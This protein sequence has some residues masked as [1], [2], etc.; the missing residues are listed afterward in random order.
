MFSAN[1]PRWL[2]SV[3][4]P[5]ANTKQYSGVSNPLGLSN[6][7]AFGRIWPANAPFGDTGVG[8]SS[9]LDPNGL[10]LATPPNKA[11]N[12]KIPGVY[13]GSLTTRD[14]VTHPPQP[15]AIHRALNTAAVGTA[16]HATS[17]QRPSRA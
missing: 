17:P 13:V 11:P 12:A 2:N 4:N 16:F 6:N 8:S 3:N 5:G 10:P 7:N 9:I 15:Q 1:S 14:A